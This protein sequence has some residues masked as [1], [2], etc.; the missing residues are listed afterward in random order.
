MVPLKTIRQA[1]AW[2]SICQENYNDKGFA[3]RMDHLIFT[4]LISVAYLSGFIAS[5]VFVVKY[6]LIDMEGAL[7]ALFQITLYF[8]ITYFH[9]AGI[10]SHCKITAFLNR[11]T[12]ICD[13]H[14]KRFFKGLFKNYNIHWAYLL[15]IVY[16]KIKDF[17][18]IKGS[19]YIFKEANYKSEKLWKIGIAYMIFSTSCF[20]TISAIAILIYWNEIF[21]CR[22]NIFHPIMVR[23]VLELLC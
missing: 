12:E 18:Q 5:I 9:L 6:A 13:M 7:Y 15:R 20:M 2:L 16:W 11:L 17:I 19:S 8:E 22:K 3:V 14:K 1:L 21:I 4:L 23:L 10:L